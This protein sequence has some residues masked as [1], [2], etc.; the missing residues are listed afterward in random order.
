MGL[1]NATGIL[2]NLPDGMRAIVK[3][4]GIVASLA[5]RCASME[6][7]EATVPGM[8][9]AE[10]VNVWLLAADFTPP[11]RSGDRITLDGV[12]ASVIGTMKTCGGQIIRADVILSMDVDGGVRAN[13]AAA[14]VGA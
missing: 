2:S 14:A 4:D 12:L 13:E 8:K 10:H 5:V 7:S 9:I 3:R 1:P 11:I 6:S